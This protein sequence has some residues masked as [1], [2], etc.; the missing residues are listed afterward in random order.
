[1]P[2]NDP[3]N[4]PKELDSENKFEH[5]AFIILC[6][7]VANKFNFNVKS[8]ISLTER[9]SRELDRSSSFIKNEYLKSVPSKQDDRIGFEITY[10]HSH[11]TTLIFDKVLISNNEKDEILRKCENR[12]TEILNLSRKSGFQAEKLKC[13]LPREIKR[14]LN[15]IAKVSIQKKWT[16]DN[17]DWFDWAFNEINENRSHYGLQ[18]ITEESPDYKK[19]LTNLYKIRKIGRVVLMYNTPFVGHKNLKDKLKAFISNKRNSLC[20]VSGRESIG[21]THFVL[22]QLQDEKLL[23]IQFHKNFNLEEYLN[24]EFKIKVP[25]NKE[26]IELFIKI[27]EQVPKNQ[28]T[29]LV[30]FDDYEEWANQ[31]KQ[32]ANILRSFNSFENVKLVVI[33]YRDIGKS[34]GERIHLDEKY[35]AETEFSEILNNYVDRNTSFTIS[36][37]EIAKIFEITKGWIYLALKMVDAKALKT[38]AG[39][40]EFLNS[41]DV[42]D[43]RQGSHDKGLE[44]L[45]RVYAA[46]L[47]D[48]KFSKSILDFRKLAYLDLRLHE[49]DLQSI[50]NTH[51]AIL[52]DSHYLLREERFFRIRELDRKILLDRG[53]ELELPSIDFNAFWSHY[54]LSYL[55]NIESNY[56]KHCTNR[57]YQLYTTNNSPRKKAELFDNILDLIGSKKFYVSS[58]KDHTQFVFEALIRITEAISVLDEEL[59]EENIFNYKTAFILAIRPTKLNSNQL[60]EIYNEVL[61]K[62]LKHSAGIKNVI[63]ELL[64]VNIVFE[65]FRIKQLYDRYLNIMSNINEKNLLLQ[66]DFYSVFV[67]T[68]LHTLNKYEDNRYTMISDL[69]WPRI[70]NLRKPFAIF[71]RLCKTDYFHEIRLGLHAIID[72]MVYLRKYSQGPDGKN[73]LE[74]REIIFL[75]LRKL[76]KEDD[77]RGLN[78]AIAAYETI[79]KNDHEALSFFDKDYE[80]SSVLNSRLNTKRQLVSVS[81]L[82][83]KVWKKT[84]NRSYFNILFRYHRDKSK[85]ELHPYLHSE[86]LL[87]LFK[88]IYAINMD[89]G[90]DKQITEIISHVRKDKSLPSASLS[91]AIG[92]FLKLKYRRNKISID[93]AK[94]EFIHVKNLS[95]VPELRDSSIRNALG[96]LQMIYIKGDIDLK[97]MRYE[98][99]QF[100][101]IELKNFDQK[102]KRIRNKPLPAIQQFEMYLHLLE[103]NKYFDVFTYVPR[104]LLRTYNLLLS[105]YNRIDPIQIEKIKKSDSAFGYTKKPLLRRLFEKYEHVEIEFL[106]LEIEYMELVWF[107]RISIPRLDSLA[108]RLTILACKEE[109]SKSLI[110][111]VHLLLSR[112]YLK[113]GMQTSNFKSFLTHWNLYKS[114]HADF[115]FIKIN[116]L[117]YNQANE[118]GAIEVGKFKNVIL[119]HFNEGYNFCNTTIEK[120]MYIEEF[121]KNLNQKQYKYENIAV[122]VQ[123]AADLLK[124]QVDKLLED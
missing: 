82:Y 49:V 81:I 103:E 77:F 57:L 41:V 21:K 118:S 38:D 67:N 106:N 25:K 122:Q 10:M 26:A 68:L 14:K 15:R 59:Y 79:F 107:H 18:E 11:I 84:Y 40:T 27:L 66:R 35:L 44:L 48:E 94:E 116:F 33:S 13:S 4:R 62:K 7:H 30:V 96:W 119:E 61:L 88:D 47:T 12:W 51:L 97:S 53:H 113:I 102:D 37:S 95:K 58:L 31:K 100:I 71:E 111:N 72:W 110:I 124:V 39:Y 34:L 121:I 73:I 28:E 87:K 56:R 99:N 112:I 80:T 78:K 36:Q 101:H 93:Q 74:T 117:S 23:Y 63:F 86:H 17:Q 43:L 3:K 42:S 85:N 2:E 29:L 114:S 89:D 22:D 90:I 16:Y 123:E 46:L 83:R 1:M 24:N 104:G 5:F 75:G 60:D 19:E 52:I 108:E 98:F 65:L 70:I 32:N 105:N 50:E 6:F 64:R 69:G 8:V 120:K 115:Q 20:N 54:F 55:D 76:M 92:G 91:T 109:A 45:Q 9:I